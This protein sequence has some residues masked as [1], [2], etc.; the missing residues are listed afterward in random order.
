VARE[1]THWVRSDADSAA[2]VAAIV[3]L[4]SGVQSDTALDPPGADRLIMGLQ[5]MHERAAPRL[6]TTTAIVTRD[7][8]RLSTLPDERRL[9]HLAGLDSAWTAL[10]SV[11][12]TH[13]EALRAAAALHASPSSPQTVAVVTSPMHTRRACAA[14][15]KAGFRV[16][17][18]PARERDHDT[19]HP[20]T[21]EDRLAAWR[22]YLYERLGWVKYRWK[23]WV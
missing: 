5:R 18:V 16:I 14:F 15:E 19:W 3:V 22:V 8:E 13:D 23:G 9:V 4:S 2:S 7:G 21:P 11:G 12:N 10:D 6:L 17:C 1:T 20:A